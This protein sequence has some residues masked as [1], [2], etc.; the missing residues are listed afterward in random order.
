MRALKAGSPEQARH[1]LSEAGMPPVVNRPGYTIHQA[2]TIKQSN[3]PRPNTKNPKSYESKTGMS[4]NNLDSIH[5]KAA[6]AGELWRNKDYTEARILYQ[7]IENTISLPLDKAKIIGNIA[8]LYG[9]EGNKT[10]CNQHSKR[11]NKNN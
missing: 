6:R 4:V 7:E 3:T 5:K 8:Q 1:E 10:K 9:E 11:S 2:G